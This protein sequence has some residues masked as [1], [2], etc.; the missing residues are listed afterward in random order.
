VI[1]HLQ[2]GLRSPSGV[3]LVRQTEVAECG[4]ACL[5]MIATHHGFNVD[6]ATLRRRFPPSLRGATLN[7]MIQ[8]AHDM[9]LLPRA[10]KISLEE[11]GELHLPAILHWNLNHFVVL[12]RVKGTRALVHNPEGASRWYDMNEISRHFTGVALEL[13]AA[14]DFESADPPRRL[15]LSH[16][17]GRLTG[18][19]R[20]IAQT[21]VLS[22]VMQ[23]FV[24]ASPYYMQVALD[25]AVPAM[26]ADLVTVLALGFALFA[27]VNAGALLLRSFVLLSAGTALGFGVASNVARQL[28]RLPVAWFER[29]HVGDILS[30]F[31]SIA[32][33]Q[34]ALTEGMV[35]AILDGAL[36]FLTLAVMLFYSPVLA[37]VAL[38]ALALY[39]LVRI[40]TFPAQ[41]DAQEA[42]IVNRGREQSLMIES[43]RSMTAMRLFG[44]EGIR[45]AHWQSRLTDAVNADV[46]LG[47]LEAWQRVAQGLTFGLETVISIWLALRLVIAGGF[48]VGMVFAYMAYKLQ[49][50]TNS[51]S[52]IEKAIAFRMLGL[53]VERLSD[54]AVSAQDV[55]F[56]QEQPPRRRL[57][58]DIELRDI[59]FRY[60]PSDPVVLD[61]I[62]LTVEAGDHVAVTGP[63]GGG[64]S[65]LVR[66]LLGLLEPEAGEM[67]VDAIPLARFGYRNYHGQ[68]ASV[69]QEDNLF[70]GSILDNIALFDPAPDMARVVEASI[71]SAIDDDIGAMP[72]GYETL[73]GDMG[74]A[75]S[76]GQRQRL[77]LARALYRR[78]RLL[79]MDEGTSQLDSARESAINARIAGMGIT[80]IVIAH[81]AETIAMADRV[82]RLDGGRLVQC[83]GQPRQEEALRT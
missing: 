12:E 8:A 46:R 63:S 58:G 44:L 68:V 34:Q 47:R 11:M 23:A 33:I 26:D 69:L 29:R 45:H 66:I 80:R 19:K 70:A 10:V 64:K 7:S 3:R 50:L 25:S 18:L 54:I 15:K 82:Y 73:V 74:S 61:R 67:R 36:A 56:A 52:L 1:A 49:F 24:L 62:C 35:A 2:L 59:V 72:M 75:L 39:A 16:L 43:V 79:V 6:L 30:R 77:L 32:P 38:L 48:S 78:P 21:L 22:L 65:T 55:S 53:H 76:G 60:S 57:R 81:R 20:A 41:R 13:R 9:S 37:A 5:A 42:S 31:Q 17:W 4:L 14:A 27:C 28:F 83:A 71:A 40:L 51:A